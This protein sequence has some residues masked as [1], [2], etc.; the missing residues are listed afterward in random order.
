[1]PVD[2]H[3]PLRREPV[4]APGADI[5]RVA[6]TLPV[7]LRYLHTEA[8]GQA[9]GGLDLD[10]SSAFSLWLLQSSGPLSAGELARRLRV[11]PPGITA[12]IRRLHAAGLVLSTADR[13]DRRRTVIEITP[14]GR[15]ALRAM[16]AWWRSTLQHILGQLPPAEVG[17][18]ADI[19]EHVV[20]ALGEQLPAGR[21]TAAQGPDQ[22]VS[23]TPGAPTADSR[24]R[25]R[26]DAPTR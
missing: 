11:T 10:G 12:M 22:P 3:G 13:E 24:P 9:P 25:E 26:P 2:A 15:G 16:N 4:A 14:A 8:R 1:M 6:R 23:V 19:L 17:A 18:L 21:R 5:V 7:V 20:T